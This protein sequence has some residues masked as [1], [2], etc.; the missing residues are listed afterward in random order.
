MIEQKPTQKT[1]NTIILLAVVLCI[2]LYLAGVLSGL[3]ANTILKKETKEDLT[4]LEERTQKDLQ[5]LKEETTEYLEDLQVYIDFLDSN[6]RNLQLQQ[7]FVD[8][9]SNGEKCEFLQISMNEL[10]SKLGFYWER[11]PYR[12]EEYELTNEPTEEYSLL[13]EQY[14][15]ISIQIFALAKKLNEQCGADIVYGL[16]FYSSDCKEC[17][18]QG[19]QLDIFNQL[20]RQSGADIVLFPVDFLSEDIIVTNLRSFYQINETPALVINNKV[21]QGKLFQAADLLP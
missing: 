20:V 10:V 13:K 18:K 2:V 21:Y 19:E 3:Y 14:T 8:T 9:L 6:L 16:H 5:I 1:R 7:A 15:Q 4:E 12:M 17:V 11:L